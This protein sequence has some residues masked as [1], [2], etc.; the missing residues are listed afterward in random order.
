MVNEFNTDARLRERE[1]SESRV[2]PLPL[3][4]RI[5]WG[6]ILAG[7]VVALLAQFALETLGVAIGVGALEPGEDRIGPSFTSAVVVWLAVSALLSLFAGG[8]VT[9]KLAGTIDALDGVLHGIVMMGLVTFISLFVLTSSIGATLRGVSNLVG[10]GLSL[11]G[12]SVEEVSTTVA[13]AVTL[14][15]D[16]LQN[17]RNEADELL[18]EDA[19]LTSLRLALDDYLLSDQPGN[20]TRQAA[21]DALATQTELTQEEAAQ[22]LNEWEAEFSQAVNRFETR[23]EAAASDIADAVASTAGILF[24]IIVLGVFA[25]GAGGL[26]AASAIQDETRVERTVTR[27]QAAEAIS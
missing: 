8:L 18:A 26:V 11:V 2:N 1:I 14:Q 12:A 21:I 19:S 17:I 5:S 15:E 13:N 20:D 24:M 3:H 6:A 25:A 9:G 23:V 10:Q 22:R 7:L 27:R 4:R 16:T